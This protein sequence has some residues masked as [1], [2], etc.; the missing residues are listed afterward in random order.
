MTKVQADDIIVTKEPS[1]RYKSK[2]ERELDKIKK[3]LE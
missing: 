3:D 2:E 1:P